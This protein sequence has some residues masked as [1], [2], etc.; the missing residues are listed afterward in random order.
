MIKVAVSGGFDPLHIGHVKYIEEAKKLG[1]YLIVILNSDD[2]LLRKKGYFFM[3]A[4]ER[5]YILKAL[6][7]VDEVFLLDSERNDVGEALR[8][9]KPDIFAKGGDR[10]PS[11]FPIPEV[12]ICKNLNI[13]II[14]KVG[15]DKIQASSTLARN[16]QTLK[17]NK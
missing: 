2:W 8:F 7:A 17:L 4:D 1:D 5:I 11:E 15:G 10:C 6:K 12:E 16:A 13:Q 3:P 9:L 14:Y